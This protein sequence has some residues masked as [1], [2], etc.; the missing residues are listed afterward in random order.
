MWR[1]LGTSSIFLADS[2][3]KLEPGSKLEEDKDFG[4]KGFT[5]K[6]KY[7]KSRSNSSGRE[8]TLVFDQEKGFDNLLTNVQ[9]LKEAKLLQGSGH[10]YYIE[11]APTKKFKMKTVRELYATDKEFKEA[12][13]SYIETLYTEFLT[14]GDEQVEEEFT[15]VECIDEEKNIWKGNDGKN[16]IYHEETGDCEE[17]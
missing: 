14:C 2:L 12:F 17:C 6:A 9:Y 4:I 5:V 3:I 15:L 16:Y 13:D 1:Y 8:M 10:G 7:I 11:T